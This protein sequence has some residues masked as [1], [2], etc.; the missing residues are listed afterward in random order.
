MP[1][2]QLF[3]TSRVPWNI[4]KDIHSKASRSMSLIRRSP[5]RILSALFGYIQVDKSIA[6]ISCYLPKFHAFSVPSHVDDRE[7]MNLAP[8]TFSLQK[9]T[10]TYLCRQQRSRGDPPSKGIH[11]IR[12]VYS[13][14]RAHA[15][16]HY[17]AL[18]ERP[19]SRPAH[20]LKAECLWFPHRPVPASFQSVLRKGKAQHNPIAYQSSGRPTTASKPLSSITHPST[21]L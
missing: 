13:I 21:Y 3:C 5:R 10:P 6:R 7:L 9:Q 16:L 4:P 17:Y 11:G 2:L 18:R 20:Q 14:I 15:Q 19:C 12:S 1:F 8:C